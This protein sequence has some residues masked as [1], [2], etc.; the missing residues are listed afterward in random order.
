M[1]REK[2]IDPE[3]GQSRHEFEKDGSSKSTKTELDA[4]NTSVTPS[5]RHSSDQDGEAIDQHDLRQLQSVDPYE[6]V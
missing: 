4:A 3:K 6:E 5:D 2:H 1:P